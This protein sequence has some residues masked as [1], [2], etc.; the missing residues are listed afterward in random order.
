VGADQGWEERGKI[1]KVVGVMELSEFIHKSAHWQEEAKVQMECKA[2]LDLL[3]ED[4]MMSNSQIAERLGWS[5]AT[6]NNRLTKL[7]KMGIIK[8]VKMWQ[9]EFK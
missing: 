6:A 9:I 7:K 3:E 1:E 4:P 5:P 2:V 8:L